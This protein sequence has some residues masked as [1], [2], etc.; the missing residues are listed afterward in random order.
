MKAGTHGDDPTLQ[1][2]VCFGVT[3]MPAAMSRVRSWTHRRPA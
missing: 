1:L 2:Y 3:D